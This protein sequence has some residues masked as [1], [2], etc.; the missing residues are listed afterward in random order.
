MTQDPEQQNTSGGETPDRAA[1]ATPPLPSHAPRTDP[2]VEVLTGPGGAERERAPGRAARALW[3]H[4]SAR[5]RAVIA[6]ATVAALALGG[7]VAYAATSE[8][9]DGGKRGPAASSSASPGDKRDQGDHRHGFG[10][11]WFG[12][13]GDA[14]HGEATVKDR[15]S[16]EWV[17]R[18]WQRGTVEKVD[19]NQVTVK[20]DDGTEWTWAVGSDTKVHADGERSTGTGA[21]KKGDTA[22]L[23]GTRTDSG[24]RTASRVLTGNLDDKG[25]GDWHGR[26]PGHDPGDRGDRGDRGQSHS[27]S[28]SGPTT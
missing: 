24:T 13:G 3:Q 7:T 6:A 26:S 25:P 22:Y 1:G 21:V 19:G 23:V 18:I 17:V 11:R 27:R 16:G 12:M 15:D 9:S 20:S 28:G 2:D 14:V 8:K 5:G 10:G 4:R